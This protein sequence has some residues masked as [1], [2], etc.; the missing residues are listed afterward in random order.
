MARAS[1]AACHGS[2]DSRSSLQSA[3]LFA[4]P[5]TGT[6]YLLREMV[7]QIAR[8]HALR[9][10][11]IALILMSLLPAGLLALHPGHWIAGVAILS[12][13]TGT[14]TARWLFFAEAEHV[15]GLYYGAQPR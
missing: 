7:Y 9:L 14:L 12:H 8:K 6:N 4:P 10:R 11:C 5:H 13:L 15:V 1:R 3:A 2:Y